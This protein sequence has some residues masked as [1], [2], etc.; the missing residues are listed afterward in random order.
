MELWENKRPVGSVC[1]DQC[2][3]DFMAGFTPSSEACS[4]MLCSDPAG[5]TLSPEIYSNLSQR[6]YRVSKKGIFLRI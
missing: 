1:Q 4:L 5:G 6:K 2:Q 3:T